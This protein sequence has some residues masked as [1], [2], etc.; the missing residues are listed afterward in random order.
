MAGEDS[1]EVEGGHRRPKGRQRHP[2]KPPLPPLGEEETCPICLYS[3]GKEEERGDEEE[4]EAFF[5]T[6]HRLEARGK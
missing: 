1:E 5:E 2:Q 4:E 3:D 6:A